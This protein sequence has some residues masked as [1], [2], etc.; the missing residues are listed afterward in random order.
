ETAGWKM[1]STSGALATRAQIVS[2]LTN[3]TA[4][5]IR[6]SYITNA[7]YTAAIDDVSI[8]QKVL[9]PAPSISS[10]SSVAAPPGTTVT[11]SGN[12]FDPM[13]ASIVGHFGP[14]QGTVIS[15][16]ATE[17]Q[18]TVPIGAAYGPL[19]VVNRTTGLVGQ[20]TE[21]FNP[22]F[23]NGGRIIPCS[24][25]DRVDISASFNMEGIT[26]AD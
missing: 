9:M 11:L 19:T 8:G 3:I 26:V 25:G 17:L 12:N 21:P 24:F 6:A 23:A 16:S 1:N 13:P 5:Q 20:S 15:A 2:V 22:V 18:V 7:A 10:V 14:V 4:I